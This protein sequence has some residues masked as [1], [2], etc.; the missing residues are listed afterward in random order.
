VSAPADSLLA[1][2]TRLFPKGLG[3]DKYVPSGIAA[4][5]DWIVLSDR[6]EPR[7]ALLKQSDRPSPR[8]VFLSLR[9]PFVALAFF[10]EQVLPAIS[11]PF[12]LVSGSEDAT[13][14]TQLDERWRRFNAQ[15]R[16]WITAIL[17]DPRLVRWHAENLDDASHP[18][19][20]PLPVGML[21]RNPDAGLRIAVPDVVPVANRPV[22]VL[23]AHR[24]RTGLQWDLRREIAQLCKEHFSSFCTVLENEVP[25]PEFL[26]LLHQHAFVICV[27]GGG[28]DPSPKAWQALLHGAIPIVRS[29]ALNEAYA[30]LPVAF[31]DDWDESCLSGDILRD[32]VRRLAPQFEAGAARLSLLDRLGIDYWWDQIDATP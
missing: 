11:G 7:T 21:F 10:I 23:C 1:M 12:V 28:L 31:V 24:A 20:R 16:G 25:E 32:W 27:E 4:R 6:N 30:R 26:H 9:S 13:V 19:F 15:E 29:N 2:S 3:A 17:D 18:K 8:H 5:C 14:P 22:R